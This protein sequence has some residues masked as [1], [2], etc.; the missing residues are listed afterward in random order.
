M[1]YQTAGLIEL[2][3]QHEGMDVLNRN[4]TK[5]S[6]NL[7]LSVNPNVSEKVIFSLLNK[8]GNSNKIN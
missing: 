5:V 2:K 1:L 7:T 4:T 8:Q 3:T 6:F